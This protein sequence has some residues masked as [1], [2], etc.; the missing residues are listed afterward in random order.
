VVLLLG[1]GV[2]E[3]PRSLWNRSGLEAA[4]QHAHA[5]AAD[6]YY[7]QSDSR[8][9]L[10]NLVAELLPLESRCPPALRPCLAQILDEDLRRAATLGLLA[11]VR[12]NPTRYAAVVP[13]G[14]RNKRA[15]GEEGPVVTQRLLSR[16]RR[17]IKKAAADHARADRRWTRLQSEATV[18]IG[19]K[20]IKCRSALNVV[21]DT[22]DHSCC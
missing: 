21:K 13:A 6:R 5:A 9:A 22:S 4:L 1:Y 18:A 16:L 19:G 3:L 20:V 15:A 8:I 14:L 11:D 12:T 2:V 10:Y 7:A 17:R